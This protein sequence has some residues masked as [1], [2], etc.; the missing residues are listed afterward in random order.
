M[1]EKIITFDGSATSYML[2][3]VAPCLTV[4]IDPRCQFNLA[5]DK[6]HSI[7]PLSI[8]TTTGDFLPT[9]W[10]NKVHGTG[11]AAH[12]VAQLEASNSIQHLYNPFGFLEEEAGKQWQKSSAQSFIFRICSHLFEIAWSSTSFHSA[13]SKL[14]SCSALK[15]LLPRACFSFRSMAISAFLEYWWEDSLTISKISCFCVA[16]MDHT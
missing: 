2:F 8:A 4:V 6:T 14:S 3:I 15:I 16:L 1:L 9:A 13:N 10:R 7:L 11:V 12:W 5:Q